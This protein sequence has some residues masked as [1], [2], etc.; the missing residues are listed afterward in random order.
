MRQLMFGAKSDTSLVCM[1]ISF[2]DDMAKSIDKMGERDEMQEN[3]RQW[4]GAG[5]M[6]RWCAYTAQ[7]TTNK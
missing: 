6:R 2:D 5:A 3:R 1:Q 7:H 4:R